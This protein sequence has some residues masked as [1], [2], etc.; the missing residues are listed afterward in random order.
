MTS[1]CATKDTRKYSASTSRSISAQRYAAAEDL[2]NI[3]MLIAL[4]LLELTLTQSVDRVRRDD[5]KR[6]GITELM[7]ILAFHNE[8]SKMG[9]NWWLKMFREKAGTKSCSR[10]P[11]YGPFYG[12]ESTS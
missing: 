3:L 9:S 2:F 1:V 12:Y 5:T 4:S 6:L 11:P 8:D 10:A 7:L